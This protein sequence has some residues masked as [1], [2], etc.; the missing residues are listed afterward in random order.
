MCEGAGLWFGRGSESWAQAP[1]AWEELVTDLRRVLAS[2]G[3]KGRVVIEPLL[4][5]MFAERACVVWSRLPQERRWEGHFSC[6][7]GEV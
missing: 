1:F 2:L 3:K 4:Y 7:E 5:V 6:E